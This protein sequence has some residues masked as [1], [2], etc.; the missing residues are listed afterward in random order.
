MRLF[1]LGTVSDA[2]LVTGLGGSGVF[3][4]F[5]WSPL[6]SS[7]GG[8]SGGGCLLDAT[9]GALLHGGCAHG[10][11]VVSLLHMCVQLFFECI[12]VVVRIFFGFVSVRS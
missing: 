5:F 8:G 4:L 11:F 9:G 2:G 12:T 1:L 6:R 7:A 3:F 10:T